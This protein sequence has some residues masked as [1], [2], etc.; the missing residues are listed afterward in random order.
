MAR[1]GD[2]CSKGS[3]N[4]AQ[5][6]L[7][8]HNGD[9]PIYGASGLIKKVDFFQQ[10]KPYIAVV[11]DGAGIGRVMKLSAKRFKRT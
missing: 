11:K 8:E 7:N 10:E 9:F 6:D 4:I 5:K 1:L 3:S 2:V